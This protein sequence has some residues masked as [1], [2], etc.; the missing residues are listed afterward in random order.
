M[1]QHVVH[2][3][4]KVNMYVEKVEYYQNLRFQLIQSI[5]NKNVGGSY[6]LAYCDLKKFKHILV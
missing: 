6:T 2:L 3:I 4:Q 5:E 1:V